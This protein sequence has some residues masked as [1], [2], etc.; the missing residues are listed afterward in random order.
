MCDVLLQDSGW[1][2]PTLLIALHES[3]SYTVFLDKFCLINDTIFLFLEIHTIQISKQHLQVHPNLPWQVHSWAGVRDSGSGI[4]VSTKPL[5]MKV[6]RL[7]R[8]YFNPY[9]L[10]NRGKDSWDAD[11][12]RV[13]TPSL[14]LET[15]DSAR[16]H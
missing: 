12:H 16:Y 9:L 8:V 5:T 13:S 14:A 1:I 10:S 7:L 6:R 3:E 2:K 4:K 11:I 15:T